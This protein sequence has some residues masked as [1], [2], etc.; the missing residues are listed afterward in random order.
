MANGM[1]TINFGMVESEWVRRVR[2]AAL[3][4]SKT[5]RKFCFD[6]IEAARVR[7]S[8]GSPE[9][10]HTPI[11]YKARS[12]GV[13]DLAVGRGDTCNIPPRKHV[14]LTTAATLPAPD[15]LAALAKPRPKTGEKCPHDYMNWMQCDICRN[16]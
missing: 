13:T 3:T 16:L 8:V 11:V 10:E 6:A 12:Q 15:K 14:E 4:E 5:L 2:L 9:T 1:S 7:V